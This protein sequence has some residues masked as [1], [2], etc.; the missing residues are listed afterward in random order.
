[1]SL[2]DMQGAIEALDA[3]ERQGGVDNVA[4]VAAT[5]RRATGEFI[6]EV[7]SALEAD[8]LKMEAAGFD[9]SSTRNILDTLRSDA[10]SFAPR[11]GG[12]A[13]EEEAGASDPARPNPMTQPGNPNPVAVP[14]SGSENLQP[15]E[16]SSEGTLD[17]EAKTSARGPHKVDQ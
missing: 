11:V 12:V 8:A 17:D 7:A 5:L 13:D 1:M 16:Q 15:P 4:D 9:A 3:A 10:G 14:Q 2:R 6:Q